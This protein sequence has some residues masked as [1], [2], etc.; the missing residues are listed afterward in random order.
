LT[1]TVALVVLILLTSAAPAPAD[2]RPGESWMERWAAQ[3][4]LTG[5]WFGARDGLASWGISPFIRYGTDVLASVAG[6]QQRGKAYAGQLTVEV[7]V[8]MEKLAGF[9]ELTFDVS[10]AWN[11]GTNL[12]DDIGNVLT[13][14]Q[15]FSGREVQ[16]AN[17]YLQQSL[18]D[19][20]LD[21]KGGRFSTGADFLTSPLDMSFVNAVL[22][23]I[24][25]AIQSNVPSVTDDP[26]TTWGGRVVARP[27]AGLSLSAGAFY[28]DLALDPL[29]ANGTEFGISGSAGYFAVG[30]VAYRLNS[31]K[32]DSG[33]PGRYRVG[34]YHDSNQYASLTNAA[35]RQRGNY[36]VY[37]LGE[38]MVYR[39]GEPGNDQGLFVFGGF[40]YA[41]Q[42]RI[43]PLPW[44]ASAAAGYRG[45]VPGRDKDTAAFAL[46]YGGFSRDLPRQTYELV[47]E[48]TYAI[49]LSR[50]LTVQPDVQYVI[51]PGGRSSV[52]NAVVVGAQLAVEF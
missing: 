14:A 24:V 31:E 36:G 45:L 52:G 3:P 1:S 44:F 13:V 30:E 26:N 9:R 32:G 35:R 29:T 27:A 43:N 15:A 46:Y 51:N 18:L 10:G 42:E 38:Q 33:L 37:V 4:Q 21:L 40:I 5:N 34:G 6:G 12:S 47:L 7:S 20:R 2:E 11:S 22:N 41:P 23:P 19:G 17:L 48:W 16:L 8:D 28:S 50:W 49:A 39:E 25:V